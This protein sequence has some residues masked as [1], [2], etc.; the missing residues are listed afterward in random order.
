MTF[1]QGDERAIG[2]GLPTAMAAWSELKKAHGDA[3]EAFAGL[4]FDRAI[5][6]DGHAVGSIGDCIASIAFGLEPEPG[7]SSASVD[8]R[9]ADSRAVEIKTTQ[10]DKGPTWAFRAPKDSDPFY[11]VC[12]WAKRDF[13]YV[14][15]H[16]DAGA[17]YDYLRSRRGSWTGQ[18]QISLGT[19][20]T[21]GDATDRAGFL[22][23][24]DGAR[25]HFDELENPPSGT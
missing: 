14:P 4:G 20:R 9:T 15:W 25:E 8:A 23:F 13:W 11:V 21:L 2:D 12:L 16:G 24:A 17:I 10:R 18:R 22:R 7:M 6:P 5:T 19:L 1:D 3:Q